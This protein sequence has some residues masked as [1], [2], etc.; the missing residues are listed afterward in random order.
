MKTFRRL[1]N[2]PAAGAAAVFLFLAVPLRAATP[3]TGTISESNPTVSWS[4]PFLTPTAGACSGDNDPA[5]DNFK[6]TIVPPSAAYGPY[7]IEVHL[8]PQ[9]DWDLEIWDPSHGSAGGSGNGPG[10][11]EVA[12][13]VNPAG[14]V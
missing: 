10:Q 4:G 11:L 13:L 12:F 6:L 7:L 14:G 3:A 1:R 5:C 9:G 2:L 8:A